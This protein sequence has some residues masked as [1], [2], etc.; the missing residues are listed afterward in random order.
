MIVMRLLEDAED[1]AENRWNNTFIDY[2]PDSDRA[3]SKLGDHFLYELYQNKQGGVLV[4]EE[5][6]IG[7]IVGWFSFLDK[8][9]A[10]EIS[11]PCRKDLQDTNRLVGGHLWVNPGYRA[12]GIGEALAREFVEIAQEWGFNGV[13]VACW[14]EGNCSDSGLAWQTTLP[15]R[16][17]DFVEAAKYSTTLLNS[18]DFIVMEFVWT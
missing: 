18:T 15:F 1:L 13:E 8:G 17:A 4:A 12:G 2:N 7:K 10:L 5:V 3:V 14:E 11:W 9:T 16:Q 6:E